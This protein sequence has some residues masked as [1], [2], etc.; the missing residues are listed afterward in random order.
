[1]KTSRINSLYNIDPDAASRLYH[2]VAA[3]ESHDGQQSDEERH[4]EWLARY[5]AFRT[6]AFDASRV[7]P[8]IHH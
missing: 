8:Y 4:A 3:W 6:I 1:M 2:Q 7:S 5:E